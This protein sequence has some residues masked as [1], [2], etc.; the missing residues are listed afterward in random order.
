MPYDDEKSMKEVVHLFKLKRCLYRGKQFVYDGGIFFFFLS[1]AGGPR[2]EEE[3][4]PE[5]PEPFEWMED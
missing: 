3:E 2:V 4:E 1:P 5:P